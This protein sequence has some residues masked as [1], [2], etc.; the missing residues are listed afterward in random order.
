MKH[1]EYTI[2]KIALKWEEFINN[3]IYPNYQNWHDFYLKRK[4]FIIKRNALKILKMLY[5][6]SSVSKNN[7]K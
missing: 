2:D 3:E 1:K 7:K 4:S 6:F 5:N